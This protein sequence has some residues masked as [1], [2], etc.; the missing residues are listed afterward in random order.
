MKLDKGKFA[1]GITGV[2]AILYAAC[3]LFVYL[4]PEFAAQLMQWLLHVASIDGRSYNLG[5]FVGGLIEVAIY[6][7]I[8][9]WL[10]AW[11][12]NCSVRE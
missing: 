2:A 4:F 9:A 10:F 6:S 8:A 11:V 5:G 12:F 3:T 1:L 7:Y